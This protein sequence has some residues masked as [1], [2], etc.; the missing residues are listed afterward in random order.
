MP[1]APFARAG[2]VIAVEKAL[3]PVNV[4]VV[5]L[6]PSN[7]GLIVAKRYRDLLAVEVHHIAAKEPL[8][9]NQVVME[10]IK[11]RYDSVFLPAPHHPLPPIRTSIRRSSN[12]RRPGTI[13][14]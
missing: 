1:G 12:C 10:G 6:P 8:A 3:C 11:S 7:F 14:G 9:R 4:S 2:V 5:F 13:R